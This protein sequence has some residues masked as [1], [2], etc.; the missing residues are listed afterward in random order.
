MSL[1]DKIM[2]RNPAHVSHKLK[3]PK[4]LEG[5]D[6]EVYKQRRRRENELIKQYCKGD[7]VWCAKA[8]KKQQ[9]GEMADGSPFFLM[10]LDKQASKGT[11]VKKEHGILRSPRET[12]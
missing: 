4:R 2:G 12:L 5:E 10:V 6:F 8:F 3:G 1:L 7:L 11:Y 9:F